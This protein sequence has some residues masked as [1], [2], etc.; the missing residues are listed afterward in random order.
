VQ[1]CATKDIHKN[2]TFAR[3]YDSVWRQTKGKARTFKEWKEMITPYPQGPAL[4]KD[5]RKLAGRFAC[6]VLPAYGLR[7]FGNYAESMCSLRFPRKYAGIGNIAFIKSDLQQLKLYGPTRKDDFSELVGVPPARPPWGEY[8]VYVWGDLKD[9]R[10]RV[11][12]VPH[13]QFSAITPCSSEEEWKECNHPCAVA[14]KEE[15]RKPKRRELDGPAPPRQLHSF[16]ADYISV[17]ADKAPTAAD[18]YKV[19]LFITFWGTPLHT[20]GSGQWV[21][22]DAK[23]FTVPVSKLAD[24]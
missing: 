14:L 19:E 5:E 21:L 10:L 18:P 20:D 2:K 1:L 13:E 8:S 24:W 23:Y 12:T 15:M 11:V 22:G 4:H 7:D 17:F 16:Y 6:E 9:H 3:W